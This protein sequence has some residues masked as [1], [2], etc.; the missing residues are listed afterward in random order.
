VH[1]PPDPIRSPR[2]EVPPRYWQARRASSRSAP[3]VDASTSELF[4]FANAILDAVCATTAVR[5]SPCTCLRGETPTAC[6][7]I[8]RAIRHRMQDQQASPSPVRSETLPG[9]LPTPA[10]ALHRQ[11]R[12]LGREPLENVLKYRLA[13]LRCV[14]EQLSQ[15]LDLHLG[16]QVLFGAARCMLF[17]CQ[18]CSPPFFDSCTVH[19]RGLGVTV[20]PVTTLVRPLILNGSCCRVL[21]SWRSL[22][23]RLHRHARQAHPVQPVARRRPHRPRNRWHRMRPARPNRRPWQLL[24]RLAAQP[25]SRSLP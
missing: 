9:R 20:A 13:H 24:W 7:V 2:A 8:E 25:F 19:V 12:R 18:V 3:I 6:R 17:G 23:A 21:T 14:G 16:G 1:S 22:R 15:L 11:R 5:R 4:G 10:G